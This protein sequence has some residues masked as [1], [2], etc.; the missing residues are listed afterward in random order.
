VKELKRR[1]LAEDR[2]KNL[3]NIRKGKNYKEKRYSVKTE[4]TSAMLANSQ[5]KNH[6]FKEFNPKAQ[7]L[8]NENGNLHPLMK[9]KQQFT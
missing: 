5:W 6:E 9:T 7:G 1:K 4:L 3:Y 8:A 2:H